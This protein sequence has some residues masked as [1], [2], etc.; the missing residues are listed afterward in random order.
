MPSSLAGL[1][2]VLIL[3][4]FL[5]LDVAVVGEIPQ[6]LLPA[7]RL[8]LAGISLDTI[9]SLMV[10][11]ISIA[12]LGMIESLLCGA[13]AGRMKGEVLNADRE[14]VAQ[15]IGN[16][17]I[18]FFGGVPATAAIARTSVAIKAGLQTR[19]TGIIHA[20]VLLLSM[21]LLAPVMSQIPL[22]ALA[23]VLMVTALRMNEWETIRYL[24][25]RRFKGAILKYLLTLVVTVCF[26]LT[27]AILAGI[28]FSAFL[29]IINLAQVEVHVSEVDPDKLGEKGIPAHTAHQQTRVVYLTGTIF[30]VTVNQLNKELSRLGDMNTLSSNT[31]RKRRKRVKLFISAAFS[32]G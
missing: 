17:I 23:A 15:G 28:A 29:F 1:I 13:S 27:V 21:F 24:F 31:A 25:G 18:P 6:T 16:M 22:S 10:P 20:V 19:L 9:S 8:S 14:L 3:N 32:P 5:N 11:A 12:A 30:F 4:A 26:N 7:S 2:V